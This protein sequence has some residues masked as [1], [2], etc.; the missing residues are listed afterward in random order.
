MHFGNMALYLAAQALFFIYS[1]ITEKKHVIVDLNGGGREDDH[2]KLRQQAAFG[3]SKQFFDTIPDDQ[4]E[5]TA[6]VQFSLNRLML[7][8][9]GCG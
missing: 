1:Y 7:R 2:G 6:N 8:R 5:G 3:F 4:A 9:P